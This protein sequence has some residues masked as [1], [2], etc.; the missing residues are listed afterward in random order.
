MRKLH[1]L[2]EGQTEE[3]VVNEIIAP[4][5]SDDDVF[6]STSILRTRLS[7]GGNPANRGGVTTWAKIHRDLKLLLRDS[8]IT[9]LTTLIDYYGFPD[10]A[11]GMADRPN[12]SPHARI[13]HVESAL[14]DAVDSGRFVPHLVLH[15]IETWVLADCS[16]LAALLG[17]PSAGAELAQ[18]VARKSGPEL[19]NDGSDTAP[20]KRIR[21]AYPRYG[22]TLRWSAGYRR[23]WSRRDQTAMPARGPMAVRS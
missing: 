18:L 17:N 16:R 23:Y 21:A 3:V 13:E 5:L 11:P 20:S 22:K 6:V 1:I 14:A 2:V 9:V 10:D 7:A 19:V 4:Y 15:E 12:G 8:S